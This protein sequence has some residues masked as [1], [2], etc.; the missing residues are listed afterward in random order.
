MDL[1]GAILLAGIALVIG[2]LVGMLVF[3]FRKE[4]LIIA[5][6]ESESFQ[7]RSMQFASGARGKNDDLWSK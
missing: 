2:F 1:T 3:S 7:M 4:C 5:P 6:P